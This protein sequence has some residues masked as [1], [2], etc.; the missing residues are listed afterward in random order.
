MKRYAFLA[1][2]IMMAI[3]VCAKEKL[4]VLYV[5]GSAN[6]ETLFAEGLDP[7]MIK[8]SV[9]ERMS[10]FDKFLRSRFTSV[11][12]IHADDYTPLMSADYDV[13]IFDGTPK[14]ISDYFWCDKI[15]LV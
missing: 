15:A 9:K 7:D 1:I 2:A 13:T 14:K 3:S 5:G 11:K 8:R 12:S 4:K 6:V 10:H